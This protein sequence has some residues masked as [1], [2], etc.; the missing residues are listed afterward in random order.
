M[1]LL[2]MIVAISEIVAGLYAL[3]NCAS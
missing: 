3:I 1:G 2:V